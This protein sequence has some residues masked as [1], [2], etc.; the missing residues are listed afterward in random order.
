MFTYMVTYIYIYVIYIYIWIYVHPCR[1][2]YQWLSTISNDF[3]RRGTLGVSWNS[4]KYWFFIV[5]FRYRLC[6]SRSRHYRNI[7]GGSKNVQETAFAEA[8]QSTSQKIKHAENHTGG[9][10][11]NIKSFKIWVFRKHW[12]R[13]QKMVVQKNMHFYCI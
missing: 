11:I 7:A 2:S 12:Q 6:V 13:K 1:E 8:T 5:F 10:K 4:R 9:S 3:S